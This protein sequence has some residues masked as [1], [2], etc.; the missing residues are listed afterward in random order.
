MSGQTLLR[1]GWVVPVAGGSLRDGAVAVADGRITWVGSWRSPTRPPG[2]V[3]DLGA[4]VLLP[5]LVNAHCHVELSYLAGT[6]PLTGGFSAWVAELVARRSAESRDQVRSASAAALDGLARGGTVA[7]GDV[8]NRLEHLDLFEAAGLRAL[9]FHELL[10]WDP[11]RAG[12]IAHAADERLAVLPARTGVSVRLAAH[13][14]H[15][16]SAALFEALAERGGPASVHLAESPDESRFLLSGDGPWRAFLDQRVGPVPFVPPASSPVRYLDRLGALR[17][18]LL[19]VHCVQADPED[20]RLLAERGVRVVLCPRSNRA[21]GVGLPPVEEL[22]EAGVEACL[23]SDSLASAPSLDVLDDLRLLRR[24]FP[25]L[26]VHC[27]VE[28]ATRNG[29][30]ALGFDDLGTLEPGKRAALAFVAGQGQIED[31]WAYVVD[32]DVPARRVEW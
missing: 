12:E 2:E 30:Q 14:P 17:R 27:L 3:V 18:G 20:C 9:V 32:C 13:A 11:A 29:A 5:G 24:E 25:A 15:S 16:V 1:A 6:V 19:A 7:V 22:L 23:G 4:G 28:M 8:S 21:L 26:P 31:A 10:G